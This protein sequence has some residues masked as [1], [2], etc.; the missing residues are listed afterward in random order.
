[1]EFFDILPILLGGLIGAALP[2][3]FWTVVVIFATVMLRR[4][5]GRAERFLIAG[6]GLHIL[7]NLLR[8]PASL[9]TH[10]LISGNYGRDFMHSVSLGYGIFID[11]IGMAGIICLIY[12]FWVK[13][14]MKSS[15]PADSVSEDSM[16]QITA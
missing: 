6:A 12:A 4:S 15:V 7:A 11:V 2:L 10:W 16:E 14:N 1:M 8:I 9:I 3:I 13:F 5:G